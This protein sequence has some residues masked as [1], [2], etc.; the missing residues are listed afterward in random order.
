M[1]FVIEVNIICVLGKIVD[2]GYLLKGFKL[3][4]WCI[5]CGLVLVEVEVEYKNKVF[6]L[7]DVCFKVVDEVVVLVKFGLVV[8]YEGKGDVLI[9][10]W[11]IIFWILLVNCVVC[12]CV[13]LEY[14]LI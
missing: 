12:L 6:F 7:I 14:V 5:D 3:V 11:I 9:V 13:D 10:I 1:D 2:N 8:G 4:Y